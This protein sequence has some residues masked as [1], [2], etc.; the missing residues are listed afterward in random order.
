MKPNCAI[1]RFDE[2]GIKAQH[3][4][5]EFVSIISRQLKK[6]IPDAKI[7]TSPYR[8]VVFSKNPKKSAVLASKV[9]GVSS[10]SPA[11][12]VNRDI[13]LIKKIAYSFFKKG[14]TFRIS[15]QRSDK[16][17]CLNSQEVCK[18]IGEY[19]YNNGGKVD[20][21]NYDLNISID[22]FSKKAFVFSEKFSGFGG[23]P[24][25]SQGKILCMISDLR[26]YLACLMMMNRGCLPI[27]FGKKI[28]HK[29]ILKNFP[30]LKINHLKD[31][32]Y[33]DF[34]AVCSGNDLNSPITGFD[35]P[36]FYPLAFVDESYVMEKFK[37]ITKQYIN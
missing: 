34:L 4:R 11:I 16:D 5:S 2:I 22:F 19:I 18:I 14:K 31:I 23:L 3:T 35:C 1:I 15:C 27:V 10:A 8:L 26:D 29:K 21:S 32:N 36:I 28:W 7:K 17:F 25:S 30:Y 13:D 37:S 9:F 6:L 12:M 33:K 20:L 24:V